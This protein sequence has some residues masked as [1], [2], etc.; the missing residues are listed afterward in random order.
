M[1][2]VILQNRRR[3]ALKRLHP[4]VRSDALKRPFRKPTRRDDPSLVGGNHLVG[5]QRVRRSPEHKC[6]PVPRGKGFEKIVERTLFLLGCQSLGCRSGS[7]SRNP[8]EPLWPHSSS[9]AIG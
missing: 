3:Q 6:S 1:G 4:T 8:I 7:G 2:N 5:S 9:A